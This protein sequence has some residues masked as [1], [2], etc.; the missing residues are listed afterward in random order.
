MTEGTPAL[1]ARHPAEVVTTMVDHVLD[2]AE[3]WPNW[4]GAPIKI[5]VDGEEPRIYTPHKAIRRVVD[6][7]L[8][9]L[10]EMESRMLGRGTEPDEWHAS[11]VTSR[12]DLL[13]FTSQDLDETRSRLRRLALIWDCRLRFLRRLGWQVAA[14]A[15]FSIFANRGFHVSHWHSFG[16][17]HSEY[18]STIE[19]AA[20][21]Q[22]G[23]SMGSGSSKNLYLY[24]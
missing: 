15:D 4:D 6:H 7:L 16:H 22:I 18:C 19:L 5:D 14:V 24:P 20:D 9:H 12:G 21:T 13:P 1:D 11:A 23:C 2:L 8:D 3:T 10:A 17:R